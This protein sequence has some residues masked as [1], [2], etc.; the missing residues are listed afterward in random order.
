M[1]YTI[2]WVTSIAASTLMIAC[3]ALITIGAVMKPGQPAV[4]GVV[5]I[6]MLCGVGAATLGAVAMMTFQTKFERAHDQRMNDLKNETLPRANSVGR[7]SP[8]DGLKIP[9]RPSTPG[10]H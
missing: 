1:R 4:L 2:C 6:G 3:L 10:T 8:S 5:L 7:Y 9:T